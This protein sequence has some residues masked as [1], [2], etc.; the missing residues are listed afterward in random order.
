[1]KKPI[2]M[3]KRC[4]LPETF[5]GISFDSVEL[6]SYCAKATGKAHHNRLKEKT[7]DKLLR[8]IEEKRGVGPYDAIMAFSGGKYSKHA[9]RL[10][11]ERYGLRVL[12]IA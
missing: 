12:T 11:K 10:F 2:K 3:C 8:V 1:M 9:L 4:V 5:L 6:C 7:R